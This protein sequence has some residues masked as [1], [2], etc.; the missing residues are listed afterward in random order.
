MILHERKNSI[1]V[2][3]TGDIGVS[4]VFNLQDQVE[5]MLVFTRDEPGEVGTEKKE[6]KMLN[7]LDWATLMIFRDPKSVDILM[8]KLQ[9]IK[10]ALTLDETRN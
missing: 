3:G 9:R 5:N 1:M 6:V 8:S 4:T 10:E 7:E 2:F